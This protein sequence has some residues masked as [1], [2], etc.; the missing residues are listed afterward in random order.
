M[1]KKKIIDKY[2]LGFIIEKAKNTM[3]RLP[4][5]HVVLD[6]E[7]EMYS[8]LASRLT[9]EE[10]EKWVEYA[11]KLIGKRANEKLRKAKEER[12]RLLRGDLS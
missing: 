7:S 8:V 3:A 2:E 1:S 9:M 10:I 6:E 4:E 11:T 5:Q 12:E